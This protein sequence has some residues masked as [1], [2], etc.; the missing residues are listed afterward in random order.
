MAP[1]RI[2]VKSKSPPDKREVSKVKSPG[3]A[4]LPILGQNNDRCIITNLHFHL[5]GG[6]ET[7]E[8]AAV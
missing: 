1:T 5:E 2:L 8:I 4:L 6:V 7:Q 3:V